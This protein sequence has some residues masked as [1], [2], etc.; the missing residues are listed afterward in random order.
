MS[1]GKLRDFVT[2]RSKKFR[3]ILSE[4]A[5]T[6][7]YCCWCEDLAQWIFSI[8]R[9]I[10][11]KDFPNFTV[12]MISEDFGWLIELKTPND[13]IKSKQSFYYT[14]LIIVTNIDDE[15]DSSDEFC[16]RF[17]LGNETEWPKFIRKLI[18]I[19]GKCAQNT[20]QIYEYSPEIF[21][22]VKGVEHAL[23]ADPEITSI[24]W[25]DGGPKYGT[26]AA[27]AEV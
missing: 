21:A 3:K 13:S 22:I 14:P 1:T 26:P 24:E 23:Q 25:W 16:I 5:S 6:E 11:E 7:N 17:E 9:A 12:E 15:T 4:N 8:T 18:K 19:F 2:F 10:L 27:Q 20:G